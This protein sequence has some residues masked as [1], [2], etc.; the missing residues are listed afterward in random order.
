MCKSYKQQV[1]SENHSLLTLICPV[2]YTKKEDH[3]LK[4][5]PSKTKLNF[6]KVGSKIEPKHE[7]IDPLFR[8]QSFEKTSLKGKIFC[9]FSRIFFEGCDAKNE[10]RSGFLHICWPV[11]VY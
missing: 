1:E 8:F 10:G 2:G 3:L 11:S 9:L 7:N 6:S 4:V 5:W